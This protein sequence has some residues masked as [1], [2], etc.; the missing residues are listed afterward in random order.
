MDQKKLGKKPFR[1]LPGGL[2][3]KPE[4]TPLTYPIGGCRIT[5]LTSD[6]QLPGNSP[7]KGGLTS[8]EEE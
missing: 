5:F 8:P 2:K 4:K 3:N 1:I 6:H 7:P